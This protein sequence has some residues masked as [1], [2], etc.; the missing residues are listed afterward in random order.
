MVRTGT[1][2]KIINRSPSVANKQEFALCVVVVGDVTTL[3]ARQMRSAR[4]IGLNMFV[5]S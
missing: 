5:L 4:E 2:Q 1:A 3:G